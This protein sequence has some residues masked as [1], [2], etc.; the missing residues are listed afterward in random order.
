MFSAL[1]LVHL[2][3]LLEK[4]SSGDMIKMCEN[5]CKGVHFFKKVVS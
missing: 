2:E 4:K 1:Q 3:M 5:T